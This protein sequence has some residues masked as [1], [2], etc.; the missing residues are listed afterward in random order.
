MNTKK[1][2][3]NNNMW[4]SFNSIAI[5]IGNFVYSFQSAPISASLPVAFKTVV[6]YAIIRYSKL[7]WRSNR[8]RAFLN[9]VP[10]DPTVIGGQPPSRGLFLFFK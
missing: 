10:M 6:N 1:Y 5:K 4:K 9:P 3:M 2:G 7:S 8:S